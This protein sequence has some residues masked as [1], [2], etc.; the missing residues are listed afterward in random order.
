MNMAVGSLT[1][2]QIKTDL[3]QLSIGDTVIVNV[4]VR[5]GARERVQAFEG[6]LIAKKGGGI[7]E[8]FTVRRL[9]HGVGVE[10]VFPLH[11][12]NIAGI[13][14]VKHGIVRRAKL[15]YLRNR[16]GKAAKLKERL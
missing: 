16:A 15:Y 5:E 13:T 11:S 3:P 7:S 1:K 14:V 9:S 10:R 6:I 12:P 8:T 4:K 2:D